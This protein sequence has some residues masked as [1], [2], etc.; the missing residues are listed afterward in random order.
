MSGSDRKRILVVEDEPLVAMM[1]QDML[2]DIGFDVIG[3]AMRVEAAL[4]LINTEPLDAAILDVNLGRERSY[5]VAERLAAMGIPFAFATGYGAAG[6][7]W[8]E[9]APILC[10]PFDQQALQVLLRKLVRT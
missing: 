8:R 4:V 6:V 5:P 9:G 2:D 7:E 10:K 3:P 1:L